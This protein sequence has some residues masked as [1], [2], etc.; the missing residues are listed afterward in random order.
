MQDPEKVSKAFLFLH[1]FFFFSF[2]PTH[3]FKLYF[4]LCHWR[5]PLL[6]LPLCPPLQTSAVSNLALWPPCCF[7][8]ISISHPSPLRHSRFPSSLVLYPHFLYSPAA[9]LLLIS[10]P[11]LSPL[12][13]PLVFSICTAPVPNLSHFCLYISHPNLLP[14]SRMLLVAFHI[15]N[16]SDQIWIKY[17][18]WCVW[19]L[20]QITYH[21]PS[22]Q[23]IIMEAPRLK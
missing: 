4:S 15:L 14:K 12:S 19:V 8:F 10:C 3:G 21:V 7:P 17:Y 23:S 18:T 20:V 9:P 1:P 16:T 22:P 13:F 5:P 11:P 2:W 6:N